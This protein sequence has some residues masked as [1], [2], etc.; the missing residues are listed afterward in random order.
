MATFRF[1]VNNRPSKNKTYVVFLCVTVDGQRKHI[2]TPIEVKRRSD[3]NSRARQNN[4]IKPAEPNYKAWN[5]ALAAE[6]ENARKKYRDLRESGIASSERVASEII[7][8]ERS[9]SFLQYAKDRTQEIYNAGGF[10]N[11]KKYNGFVNKLEGFLTGKDG[12][13]RDLTFGELTPGLLSKFEAYMHT[14]KNER[15]PEKKLHPNTIKV[16]FTIFKS[17]VN[18]AIEVDGHIKPEKNPFLGYTYKGVPTAKEKL[19]LD[20][21]QL[22]EGL[23]LEPGSMLWHVRNYFLFSFYCAGIRAGDLIQL[24]WCNITSEGRLRY[25]MGKN[26]KPSDFVIV[27]QAKE[28]LAHYRQEDSKQTDYIFPL[29]DSSASYAA[30]ITQEDKDTLPT[31]L[32]IKLFNQ[33]AAKNALINKYL[34]KLTEAA[35]IEKKVSFHI[36]RHSFAKVAKQKGVDNANLK[37]LL[38]HHSMKVTEVYMDNFDTSEDD[39]ALEA[40]FATPQKVSAQKEELLALLDKMN[41]EDISAVLN[42][43]KK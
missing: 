41:P 1:G 20:E 3:F 23:E 4:W 22:I 37:N 2:K 32:K 29:L 25:Q 12:R 38:R 16:N 33:V 39:K 35:K 31:E 15:E 8:G 14:L 13:V 10:R 7:A 18:R 26:H 36:S 43:L 17:I 27:A 9:T 28:I 5:I 21:I 6:L 30:A 19:N 11:W 42:G 24:R 40:M 34:R